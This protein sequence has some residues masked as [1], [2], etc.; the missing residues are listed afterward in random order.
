MTPVATDP[1]G[2]ADS[3]S[4]LRWFVCIGIAFAAHIG[5]IFTL[6][7]RRPVIP[8]AVVNAPAIQFPSGRNHLPLLDNPTLFALP[9][10]HGFAASSWLNLPPVE[11]A[12]FRWS[13]PP[14]LL[15]LL[16]LPLTQLGNAFLHYAQSNAVPRVELGILP[17]PELTRLTSVEP[18]TS[19]QERS[20]ARV[21]REL[22]TRNWLNPPSA[23]RSWPATELLTNSVIR[24]TVDPDGRVFSTTLMPPGSGV[25][26]AD[27]MALDLARSARFT[28]V[29]RDKKPVFGWLIFEW[30]TIPPVETNQPPAP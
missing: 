11:F 19:L 23:L 24:V 22:A 20:M 5:L 3:W 29:S 12:P 16:S 1:P 21:S 9:H 8:R 14:Q 6:G 7:N 17:P 15:P 13:E 28:P 30:H 27:Q 2:Q 26:A 4:R 18:A 25:K 10:P